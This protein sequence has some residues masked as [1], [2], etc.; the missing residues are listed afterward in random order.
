MGATAQASMPVINTDLIPD[1]VREDIGLAAYQGALAFFRM[2]NEH[3]DPILEQRANQLLAEFKQ[4]RAAQ[5]AG[6]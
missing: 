1:H 6:G 3:P 5:K 2:L 4:R